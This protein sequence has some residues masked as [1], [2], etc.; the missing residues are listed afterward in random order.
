MRGSNAIVQFLVDHGAKLEARNTL[1]WTP[2]MCAEGIFVANTLKDWPDTVALIRKL[3]K[4]HGLNPD[5]YNQAS[6]GVK[7]VLGRAQ[8]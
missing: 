8:Q 7:D 3:M 4:D 6:I 1:G 5:Q 2:L